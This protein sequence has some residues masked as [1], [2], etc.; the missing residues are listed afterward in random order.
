VI[1]GAR[2]IAL[3][4][5][6]AGTAW[7]LLTDLMLAGMLPTG[8]GI[9]QAVKGLVFVVATAGIIYVLAA[10]ELQEKRESGEDRLRLERRLA[11]IERFEAVG[12]L[13]SGIAHD[14]NNLLTVIAGNIETYL[15]QLTPGEPVPSELVEARKSAV[16][17]AQLTRQL[18][19]VGRTQVMRP[20]R[21]DVN[22]VILGM[23]G[24]LNGLSGRIQVDTRLADDPWPVIVD[25]GRLEQAVLNLAINA[26][27][28]MPNG[29][30]LSLLTSN[31]RISATE[32]TRFPFPFRPGDYVRVDVIDT[33]VGIPADIQARI[34]EPFFTTKPK[35]VGTG[36][37][38]STVYG[39]VKQSGGYITVESEPG[40]GSTFSV[41]L[42][43]AE[44]SQA[45]PTGDLPAA[46]R[47]PGRTETILVVEDDAAV[48]SFTTRVLRGRGFRVVEAR[49]GKAALEVIRESGEGIHMLVT[50]CSMPGMS[51]KQLIHAARA[52]GFRAPILL[53]SGTPDQDV[54]AAVPWLAKP[55][56]AAD[57]DRRVRAI[58][59]PPVGPPSGSAPAPPPAG[60]A[61]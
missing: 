37:G 7:I 20:E 36:L 29:G 44:P 12:Q 38:L 39:V 24:L 43:R 61:R 34:F 57:L 8:T 60:S 59:H 16:R 27:D 5:L 56:T 48:R 47:A 52:A 31:V 50:D 9:G 25:P 26:R 21:V 1:R 23:A 33:G 54:P 2:R 18:L 41:F 53:V 35:D 6:V 55:F 40:T 14:F 15:D 11:A 17:G 46:D 28:A 3:L 10:R 42:A 22:D 49:D 32:A 13:A 51:G 19:A 58:L 45:T 4:Y 30:T